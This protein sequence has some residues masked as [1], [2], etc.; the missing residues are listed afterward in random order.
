M[1]FTIIIIRFG[2]W[3]ALD[4][5]FNPKMSVEWSVMPCVPL[6]LTISCFISQGHKRNPMDLN[7][8]SNTSYGFPG[9]S[10]LI[11]S[12]LLRGYMTSC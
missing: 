9:P 8:I 6:L 5:Y 7:L 3:D 11:H 12:G 10:I 4:A 1:Y 2:D